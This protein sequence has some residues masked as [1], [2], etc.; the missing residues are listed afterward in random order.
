[1][2]LYFNY[3]YNIRYFITLKNYNLYL[4][5]LKAKIIFF[6]LIRIVIFYI[7]FMF[8]FKIIL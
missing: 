2:Q 5:Y 3:N 7:L 1:M 4:V 8:N 6:N